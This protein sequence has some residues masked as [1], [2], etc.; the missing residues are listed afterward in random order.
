[1]EIVFKYKKTFSQEIPGWAEL[2]GDGGAAQ[3]ERGVPGPSMGRAQIPVVLAGCAH[4]CMHTRI[5]AHTCKYIHRAAGTDTCTHM[6]A[7]PWAHLHCCRAHIHI[8]TAPRSLKSPGTAWA[9][10]EMVQGEK[11][12]AE[13]VLEG[14]ARMP[15]LGP[16]KRPDGHRAVELSVGSSPNSWESSPACELPTSPFAHQCSCPSPGAGG[17]RGTLAAA[18]IG[19]AGSQPYCMCS[20]EPA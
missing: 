13:A 8:P 14:Q 19:A 4:I 2:R 11:Q 9:H 16:H 17:L 20:P 18:V 15:Q 10:P 12:R 3:S 1:M 6:D 5:C 7:C